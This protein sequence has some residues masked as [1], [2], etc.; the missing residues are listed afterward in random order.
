MAHGVY[1]DDIVFIARSEMG[2]QMWID[3]DDTVKREFDLEKT[4]WKRKVMVA[5]SKTKQIA[6]I[7]PTS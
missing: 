4:I 1:A 6:L 3:K 7:F 5:F 2:L